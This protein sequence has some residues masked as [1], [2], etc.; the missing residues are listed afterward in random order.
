[1][2][3]EGRELFGLHGPVHKNDGSGSGSDESVDNSIKMIEDAILRLVPAVGAAAVGMG[4]NIGKVIRAIV[5]TGQAANV[6]K[7]IRKDR[8]QE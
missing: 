6:G 1:M 5:E 8:G 2:G 7:V 4:K 3:I